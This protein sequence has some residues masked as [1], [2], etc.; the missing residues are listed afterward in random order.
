MKITKQG[1]AVLFVMLVTI[2][3]LPGCG[4]KKNNES[5]THTPPASNP[6]VVVP[7]LPSTPTAVGG[8]FDASSTSGGITLTFQG[9]A[10]YTNG[11]QSRMKLYAHSAASLPSGYTNMY[12]RQTNF[13]DRVDVAL[14]GNNV[15]AQVQIS[16]SAIALVKSRGG[17]I[18]DF[19]I[20]V[21]I[22]NPPITNGQAW[23]GN[24]GGGVLQLVND[25]NYAIASL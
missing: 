8:C 5:T 13:G 25:L 12:W 2:S 23:T 9:P 14:N 7:A 6:V 17:K 4:K 10:I 18:C 21:S 24:I 3:I 19:Y 16:P 15:F 22:V 1:K 20:N 11:I